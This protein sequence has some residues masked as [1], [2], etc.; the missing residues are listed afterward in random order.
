MLPYNTVYSLKETHYPSASYGGGL[1]L[2]LEDITAGS[3]WCCSVKKICKKITIIRTDEACNDLSV[4]LIN[5]P[6]VVYV[7]WAIKK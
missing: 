4:L 3:P 1:P 6:I 2:G 7:E 5:V